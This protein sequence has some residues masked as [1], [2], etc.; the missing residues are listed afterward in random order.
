MIFSQKHKKLF[1]ILARAAKKIPLREIKKDILVAEYLLEH[2]EP[3][4]DTKVIN[5]YRKRIES[6]KKII[7]EKIK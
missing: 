7:K 5:L 4:Q 1:L 2:M 3:T 6:I